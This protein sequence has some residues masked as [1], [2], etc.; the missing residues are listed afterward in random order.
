VTNP[1]EGLEH[2]ILT[3]EADFD[4]E[5]P[6]CYGPIEVGDPVYLIDSEWCC[7][8]CEELL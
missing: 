1:F 2:L 8:P 4:S 6:R 3:L 5:C 7:E